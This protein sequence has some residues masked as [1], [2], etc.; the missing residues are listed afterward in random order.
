MVCGASHTIKG[1]YSWNHELPFELEPQRSKKLVSEGIHWLNDTSVKINGIQIMGIGGF[2]FFHYME[3]EI[4][5]DIIA[6]HYPPSGILNDGH[7]SDEIR[8]FVLERSP[9]YHIFGHNHARYGKIK[10]KAIPF[11]NAS[12]YELLDG[13]A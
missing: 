10:V 7:G 5:I 8:E 3:S 6:S 4:Q 13:K 2:P 1:I 11:I 12:L 9:G